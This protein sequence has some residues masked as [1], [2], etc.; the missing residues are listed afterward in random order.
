M[1]HSVSFLD[2]LVWAGVA[3]LVQLLAF[4]ALRLV[5]AD[6]SRSIAG[7]ALG[8]AVLRGTLSLAAG[9][10]NAACLTY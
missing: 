2:M 5:F 1:S 10:L 7:D 9:I 3:L 4:L 6:L 8:P